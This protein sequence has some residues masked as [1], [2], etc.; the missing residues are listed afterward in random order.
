MYTYIYTYTSVNPSSWCKVIFFAVDYDQNS[1]KVISLMGHFKVVI[2]MFGAGENPFPFPQHSNF[3][4]WSCWDE[5]SQ[6]GFLAWNLEGPN[7]PI[8]YSFLGLRILSRWHMTEN[9]NS[10]HTLSN[11]SIQTALFRLWD[12]ICGTCYLNFYPLLPIL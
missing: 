11:G 2:L 12:H 6:I 5:N 7:Q 4:S 8:R 10:W 1:C 9:I 3:L